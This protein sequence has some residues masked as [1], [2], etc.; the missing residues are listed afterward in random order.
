[1]A[2]NRSRC[3][4]CDKGVAYGSCHCSLSYVFGNAVGWNPPLHYDRVDTMRYIAAFDLET[5]KDL[6]AYMPWIVTRAVRG[7]WA[8]TVDSHGCLWAGGDLTKTRR[9]GD[10]K[11]QA[12]TGFAR[13]C[14]TDNI[15]PSVPRTPRAAVNAD[16]TVTMSWS[17]STDAGG[18]VRYTVF[19][20][21]YVV[22]TVTGTSAKLPAVVGTSR[23][24][25]RAVDPTGNMSATTTPVRVVVR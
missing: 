20:D 24:A 10:G 22:A 18:A 7:P 6:P 19:R 15:A 1:M 3:Y 14:R 8:L 25:V 11:W 2:I 21:D 16:K 13:F 9:V 4:V 17:R 12:S 23:Y 5:G